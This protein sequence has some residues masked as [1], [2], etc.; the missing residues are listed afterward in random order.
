MSIWVEFRCENR[1]NPSSGT[2]KRERDRCDSHDNNGPQGLVDESRDGMLA[3]IRALE[4]EAR[5]DGW[6]RTKYGWICGYCASQP[7]VMA[8]LEA[9]RQQALAAAS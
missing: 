6:S 2:N 7:M 8:E 3:G 9:E 4:V 5:D 1:C